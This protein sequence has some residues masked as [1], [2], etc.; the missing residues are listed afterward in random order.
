MIGEDID[1]DQALDRMTEREDA[2]VLAKAA[3]GIAAVIKRR[4]KEKKKAS[5]EINQEKEMRKK[6]KKH[7]KRR[8]SSSIQDHQIL[9]LIWNI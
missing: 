7:K 6:K 8:G 1:L 9:S 4:N 2:E 5:R 3:K